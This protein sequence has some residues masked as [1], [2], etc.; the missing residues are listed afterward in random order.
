MNYKNATDFLNNEIQP[1]WPKWRPT[2]IEIRDW[3]G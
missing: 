3:M 1:R 2:E